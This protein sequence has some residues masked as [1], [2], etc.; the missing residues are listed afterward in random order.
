MSQ[1]SQHDKNGYGDGIQHE[2]LVMLIEYRKKGEG[3]YKRGDGDE[4]EEKEK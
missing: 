1:Q 2:Q 4:H 3:D